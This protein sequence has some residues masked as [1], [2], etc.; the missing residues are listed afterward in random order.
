MYRFTSEWMLMSLQG[1]REGTVVV[2]IQAHN[3]RAMGCA[4]TLGNK[5]LGG[6][7]SPGV[8]AYHKS[9]ARCSN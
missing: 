5:D 1:S 3:V 7:Q 8:V 2:S 6:R 9:V 4:E